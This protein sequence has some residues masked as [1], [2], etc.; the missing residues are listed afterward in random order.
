MLRPIFVATLMAV[1]V[2]ATASDVLVATKENFEGIIAKDD[3]TLVKFYA[4]WCGH[5]K[6]MAPDFEQAATE[7][8]GKAQLVDL[9]ATVEKDLATKY[10]IRGFPTLKLFS[11]GEHI[12]DY[13]GG[14]TKDA[15]VQYIERAMLPSVVEC[16]DAEAVSKFVS[17]NE[18]KSQVFGVALKDLFVD[19][20]KASMSVRDAMPDSISFASVSDVALLKEVA[21]DD[22]TVEANSVLLVRDD[23]TSEVFKGEAEELDGWIKLSSLPVF[24]ELSRENA[25]TYT[26][27]E[28][29]IILYFQDPDKKNEE[30]FNTLFEI[31]KELRGGAAIFTWINIV[32]LKAFAEHLG[33][34]SNSP[35]IAVYDFKS[36]VKYV[37]T[38]DFSKESVTK[39][40]NGIA[41]G[42]IVPTMKSEAIPEKNDE[43]VKNIVG[44]TWADIVEDESKDVLVEQYAPWCGH[45]KKLEPILTD[46]AKKLA[47]V[48]TLVIAKMDATKNDAPKEY[49]AKG[50]PTLHFFP[51][52]S[53]VGKP[54]EGGRELKDIVEYLKENATHKEGIEI[55]EGEA[56]EAVEEEKKEEEEEEDKEEL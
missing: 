30:E 34:A 43:P 3:L 44:H 36:D 54:F 28:K 35:A 22:V 56:E 37:F 21:G 38:E 40:V 6:K 24:S 17:E 26:E 41:S 50:Y 45:C 31:A 18:G 47:G 33:V 27:I 23:K 46:L 8:K 48:E 4:P 55:P 29:P 51:A 25:A 20:K 1:A 39:W 14:R 2:V 10:G 19:F 53:K 42:E 16:A 32:E 9:D 52:G 49:K 7:L 11:K 12:S 15:L 13:K 5:C